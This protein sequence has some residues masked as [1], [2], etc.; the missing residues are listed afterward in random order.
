MKIFQ[1]IAVIM[2]TK[3]I[4]V[5]LILLS[6]LSGCAKNK[7]II[8]TVN[9]KQIT[10]KDFKNRYEDFLLSTGI[11][12]NYP[13][14]RN[15]LN[16]MITEI[17]LYYYDDNDSVFNNPEF[18]KEKK[19]IEDQTVL[20]YL[21]D[22]EIFAKLSVTEKELRQTFLR[23]N[24]RV[25]ARHLYAP[26]L[27]EANELYDL[28]QHGADFNLLARQVFTDS[29]LQNNGG[30]LGYFTWGDMDP[31]FENVAF[32]LKIGEIS[33]PVKTEEGYSIIKVEDR[34]T[35]P[36][37]TENEFLNKKNQVKRVLLIRKKRPALRKYLNSLIEIDKI[38]FNDNA[39]K[40]IEDEIKKTF[41][42]K[43]N[44]KINYSDNETASN[45]KGK[46]FS[47]GEILRRI[48]SIPYYHRSKIK[49]ARTIKTAIKGFYLH[50]ALMNVAK[51]KGYLDLPIVKKKEHQ[52][53][54]NVFMRYKMNYIAENANIPDSLV[55]SFYKENIE[56][57]STH[58]KYNLREIIVARK[59]LADSLFNVVSKQPAKFPD[60][61]RKFSLRKYTAENGGELGFVPITKL[62]L[63][64]KIIINKK[65]GEIFGPIKIADTYGVFQLIAKKKG[66]VIPYEKVKEQAKQIAKFYYRKRSFRKY[67]DKIFSRNHVEINDSLLKNFKT[68][69]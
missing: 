68:E 47:V 61:A 59:S 53:L 57:F 64:R 28:L 66:E 48:E 8:A 2:K 13:N 37:I 45:Y 65:S 17:L 42:I 40:K 52:Y 39:I 6:I 60:L 12:D 24:Q 20:G 44:E 56:Y 55:R 35:R 4:Y 49:D 21:Q 23:L 36:I 7:K 46:T 19:W 3:L 1:L 58:D 15:I 50:D 38:K 34:I 31:N 43:N 32:T 18:R 29:T 30:Y 51:E 14:R 22:R 5:S 67:M 69:I 25:A 26:T 33:K 9:D 10:F 54:I 63:L 62:G 16:S 27:E 41:S 11:K